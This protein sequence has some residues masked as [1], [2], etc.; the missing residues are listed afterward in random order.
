[1]WMADLHQRCG[2][3]LRM[4]GS[5]SGRLVL[6]FADAPH[7]STLSQ[8][9]SENDS[10]V[11][12]GAQHIHRNLMGS[13]TGGISALTVLQYA[14]IGAVLVN[15]SELIGETGLTSQEA[16]AQ[17]ATA[18]VAK[19]HIHHTRFSHVCL[20][21]GEPHE[22]ANDI[23]Q[24][25]GFVYEQTREIL[26]AA[27]LEGGDIGRLLIA[28]EPRGAIAFQDP[29]T[30]EDVKGIPPSNEHIVECSYAA[31][32]AVYDVH[33][34]DALSQLVGDLYGGS[35]KPVGDPTNGIDRFLGAK[36]QLGEDNPLTGVLVGTA[37]FGSRE[38]P[39]EPAAALIMHMDSMAEAEAG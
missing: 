30:G 5:S 26:E 7:L 24:S 22:V 25:A 15:H 23:Q 21:V 13:H 35:V 9:I 28:H 8:K 33:G 29:E 38:A 27:A 1:M 12:G 16:G 11:I 31:L 14:N 34:E 37:T 39:A 6:L 19:H 32:K 18:M 17:L 20:C 2:M 36:H 4:S 3:P 10:R